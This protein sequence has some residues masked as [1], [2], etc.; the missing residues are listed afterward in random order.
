MLA[1]VF[2]SLNVDPVLP[3]INGGAHW[4]AGGLQRSESMALFGLTSLTVHT[5]S[6]VLVGVVAISWMRY[7]RVRRQMPG[8]S[9]TVRVDAQ[10]LHAGERLL[11]AR[12]DLA[13]VE[14]TCVEP[15]FALVVTRRDGLVLRAP[16]ASESE[17]HALAAALSP[18]HDAS[19]VVFEGLADGRTRETR[20][21]VGASAAMALLAAVH[22]I[23]VPYVTTG[24]IRDFAPA[25]FRWGT[26][27]ELL[28]YWLLW[29]QR[30]SALP[31]G[32]L[33]ILA[34]GVVVRRLTPG[35]VCVSDAGLRLGDSKGRDV[36]WA[37]ITALQV[38]PPLELALRDGPSVR[39]W[40]AP[41][42]PPAERDQFVERVRA[43]LG[44]GP[45]VPLALDPVVVPSPGLRAGLVDPG[46]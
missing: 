5:L 21:A 41:D 14:V 16:L 2:T 15:G 17:A 33:S 36:P 40:L 11:V 29:L 18:G 45:R 46:A 25:P 32:A 3:S 31:V 30:F 39:L 12:D 26:H 19:A 44:V 13:G 6:L 4:L 24:W 35:R 37:D 22:I 8:D 1:A 42:R 7:V 43:R 38:G 9:A 20:A 27:P 34:V 23:A 10:G 28:Q